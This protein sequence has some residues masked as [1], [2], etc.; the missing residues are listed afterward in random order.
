MAD[1]DIRRLCTISDDLSPEDAEVMD[2]QFFP[3]LN[4]SILELQDDLIY[5]SLKAIDGERERLGCMAALYSWLLP[6]S[7][8]T[9]W[10]IY[11]VH[12][13]SSVLDA[14]QIGL[15][16]ARKVRSV[17]RS[18][19]EWVSEP[20]HAWCSTIMTTQGARSPSKF[21]P[22]CIYVWN[23]SPFVAIHIQQMTGPDATNWPLLASLAGDLGRCFYGFYNSLASAR[24]AAGISS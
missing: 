4:P 8:H 12:R 23:G 21:I 10:A 18:A 6:R 7:L 3:F 16:L 14:P 11:S 19:V 13:I 2:I 20:E 22:I 1:V 5:R 9:A 24:S 17:D 15:E